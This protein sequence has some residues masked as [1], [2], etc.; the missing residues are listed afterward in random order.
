MN[1][2]EVTQPGQRLITGSMIGARFFVHQVQTG[3]G[4]GGSLGEESATDHSLTLRAEVKNLW[5]CISTSPLQS[6]LQNAA[7]D[8]LH[9]KDVYFIPFYCYPDTNYIF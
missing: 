7:M 6:P 1:N 8:I 5:N 9:A 2:Y 4:T 3:S